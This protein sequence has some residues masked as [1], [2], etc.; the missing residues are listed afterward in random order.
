MQMKCTLLVSALLVSLNACGPA[1]SNTDA[2]L[3]Y[4][5]QDAARLDMAV[6]DQ[7]APDTAATSDAGV[8]DSA[9]PDSSGGGSDSARPDSS[10][11]TPDSAAPDSAA[12]D[13]AQP[14]S[15]AP[16]S[17]EPDQGSLFYGPYMAPGLPRTITDATS[18][19]PSSTNTVITVP[20]ELGA[21]F[22]DVHFEI[23]H[24]E[25]SDLAVFL[26]APPPSSAVELYP[27]ALDSCDPGTCPNPLVRDRLL[28]PVQGETQGDWVL[29]VTDRF[30]TQTGLLQSYTVAFIP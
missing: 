7:S 1:P 23:A 12:P 14:D 4:R 29:R 8:V 3:P 5:P 19:S 10:S 15:S 11:T 20:V 25:V 2:A 9:R 24:P 13:S 22:V 28:I 30:Q 27:T 21:A 16:D 17:G 18:S 6:A 26:I